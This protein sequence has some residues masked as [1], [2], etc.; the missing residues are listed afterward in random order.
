MQKKFCFLCLKANHNAKNCRKNLTCFKCKEKHHVSICTYV[1]TVL[2][3]MIGKGIVKLILKNLWMIKRTV[4]MKIAHAPVETTDGKMS[5]YFKIFFY[6]GLQVSFITPR[7]KSLLILVA[8]ISKQFSIKS[9]GNK[10]MKQWLG[11]EDIVIKVLNH[12]KILISIF[13]SDTCLPIYL[14]TLNFWR[15]KW[16]H[17][18][19]LNFGDSNVENKAL[20]IYILI[21]GVFI[22]NLCVIRVLGVNQAHLQFWQ[23]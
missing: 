1:F 17:L 5:K 19:D 4:K 10:E 3:V 2:I 13:A 14:Q 8:R 20:D 12:E 9:F 22:G 11:N 23:S 18:F 16:R 15:H 21:K 6:S 7:A